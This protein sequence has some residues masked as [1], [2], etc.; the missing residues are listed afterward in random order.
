MNPIFFFGAAA[1]GLWYLEK[2]R[3][4][5]L[6]KTQETTTPD[7][8]RPLPSVVDCTPMATP[9][10]ASLLELDVGEV[11]NLCGATEI[12]SGVLRSDAVGQPTVPAP[13]GSFT[14][15]GDLFTFQQPGVYVVGSLTEYWTIRVGAALPAIEGGTPGAA[16]QVAAVVGQTV[17]LNGLNEAD[18]TVILGSGQNGAAGGTS[19]TIVGDRFTA[20]Q[21]GR[22]VVTRTMGGGPVWDINVQA[23]AQTA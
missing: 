4:D 13:E 1:A 7:S 14:R 2:R 17:R 21:E 15:D 23:P 22:Y 12:N 10:E 11:V 16:T 19:W 6:A 18:F 5:A 3:K 20:L 9:G 8:G